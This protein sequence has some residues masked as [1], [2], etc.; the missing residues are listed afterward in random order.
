MSLIQPSVAA[1]VFYGYAN[2]TVPSSVSRVEMIGTNAVITSGYGL[3]LYLKSSA[4]IELV[5][6]QTDIV[7]FQY[8][9]SYGL[10][11]TEM[12]VLPGDSE[13]L[14]LSQY[15]T[16]GTPSERGVLLL[17]SGDVVRTVL[18]YGMSLIQPSVAS[19]VFYGYANDGVPSL[20][21][22]VEMIGTNAVIT[23]GF[24]LTLDLEPEIRSGENLLFFSS[25]EVVD[26]EA[27][28]RLASFPGLSQPPSV[29]QPL[30]HIWPDMASGR[31]YYF[32]ANSA[33]FAAYSLNNYQLTGTV[34][35]PGIFGSPK[36]LVR[37][38]SNG[39]A[40]ATTGGQL[41]SIQSSIVP[42]NQPAELVVSQTTP[43]STSLLA[44]FTVSILVSNRGPGV[45][46]GVVAYDLLPTGMRFVSASCTQGDVST[47]GGALTASLGT[48]NAG[49]TAQVSILLR[50]D[51]IGSSFNYVR[52][53]ANEPDPVMINNV[54]SQPIA[55][56]TQFA[57]NLPLYIGD[58][59]Y[60]PPRGRVFAAVQSAGAYSNSIVQIN[61]L[62]GSIEQSLH[63][64][65]EPGKIAITS[66]SQFLYVGTTQEPI[67]ARV[68]IQ[69]WTNDLTFGLGNDFNGISYIVGDFAPLPGQP[70][71]IAVSMHTWYGYY[72]PQ[73]AIFDDGVKRTN[74]LLEGG[75]GTYFIQASPNAS[76]LYVINA[77][78]APG[79]AIDPLTF[80][81]YAIDA[82]GIG[83]A[84]TKIAGYASDFKI[85]DKR[86]ITESGQVINLENYT[87]QGT[88]PV[89]GLVAPA[90]EDGLVYFLVQ[91]GSV[92]TPA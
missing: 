23:S 82:S 87:P 77:D 33:T 38:G 46:T 18:P 30:N 42:T 63:T 65:F 45:A 37:W 91:S 70:H 2:D 64:A 57:Q 13:S 43:S 7:S 10:A 78:A 92:G 85:E 14:L 59:A 22:R 86:L 54:A 28:I 12:F 26:P 73:L 11:L 29:S 52:V 72:T 67:V 76:M 89:A 5:D 90:L 49:A 3:T 48:L 21:S 62:T 17:H 1:N 8:Q 32:V 40:F 88:F 80:I 71:S 31:V 81:P 50:P 60:D 16:Q 55:I 68:D 24:G 20:V 27:M 6:L 53:A 56:A 84:Q 51:A 34:R 79:F 66:D 69:A 9:L 47:N 4:S 35:V 75:G 74:T 61:P 15:Y 19:N 25:G 58:L 83:A 39:L 44:D 36:Q 41:F